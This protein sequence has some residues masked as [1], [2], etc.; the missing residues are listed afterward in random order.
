MNNFFSKTLDIL[1]SR[2]R[3]DVSILIMIMFVGMIL[4][5]IG[6]SLVIPVVSILT[7]QDITIPYPFLQNILLEL[8]NPNRDSLIIGI[9]LLLF[10][11]YL[12]KNLFLVFF[13]F[14]QARFNFNFQSELSQRLFTIY[15]RQPY[16][17]HSKC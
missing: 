8:G 14:K 12:V 3:L 7:Q 17:F 5:M 11:T 13:A 9:M 2:N 6:V 10:L 1:T 16:T 15:L 4:E